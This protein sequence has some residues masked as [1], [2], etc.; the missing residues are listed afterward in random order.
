MPPAPFKYSASQLVAVKA[1]AAR[2]APVTCW[3]DE[4]LS[5]LKLEIKRH[6]RREQGNTCFYC[7][8]HIPVDHLRVWDLDHIAPKSIYPQFTFEPRNLTISCVECNSAKDTY[9]SIVG[10]PVRYPTS[11]A[12]FKIVHAHLDRWDDHLEKGL[13]RFSSKSTKGGETI[14]ACN[15]FRF[16]ERMIG[17]R[18]AIRDRRFEE[19]VERLL[20]ARSR[21][22]ARDSLRLIVDRYRALEGEA[23]TE[24][25]LVELLSD[26]ED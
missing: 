16:N 6:Y 9:D 26:E 3:D 23:E 7:R 8:S 17:A 15:L 13:Y 24:E 21:A 18:N 12:R 4:T 2:A 19:E 11:S 25:D 5:A 14:Y 22:E 10:R 20:Y 1:A